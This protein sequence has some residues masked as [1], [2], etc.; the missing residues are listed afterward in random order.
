MKHLHGSNPDLFATYLYNYMFRRFYDRELIF[1]RILEEI[2]INYPVFT[3]FAY[4]IHIF[5]WT[6]K[7]LIVH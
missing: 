7:S 3:K 6:I 5:D 2:R 4:F 1:Q